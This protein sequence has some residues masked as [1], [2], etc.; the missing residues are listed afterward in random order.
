MADALKV[1]GQVDAGAGTLT[2]LYTVPGA[3]SVSGSSLVVCNRNAVA[4]RFRASIAVA[5]AA[6]DPKQ[7]IYYDVLVQ[8]NDTFVATIGLTLAATDVVRV[9][10]DI[11]GVS[12]STF[13][14]EVT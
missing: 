7:Y 6:D 11:G 4:V 9:L 14:V 8:A 2:T 12:F 1:L 5:G 10:S 3:T 13:G